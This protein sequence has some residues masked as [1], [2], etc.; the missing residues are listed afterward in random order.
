MTAS[1]HA[2]DLLPLDAIRAKL[3]RAERDGAPLGNIWRTLRRETQAA[4]DAHAWYTPFVAAVTGDEALRQDAK[5]IIARFLEYAELGPLGSGVQFHFWCFAFP[6]ARWA[7]WFDLLRRLGAYGEREAEETAAT[8]LRLQL[9]DY[10]SGLLT[11]PHPECVDNQ[12]ASLCLSSVVLGTLF[13]DGPGDGTLAMELREEALGRAEAMIGGMPASGYSGEGSTYQGVV[14][15]ITIPF[16]VEFLERAVGGDWFDRPCAPNGTSAHDI[17]RMTVR[18]WQPSGLLLPWDDYGYQFG[19]KA[20]IAF[21]ARRTGEGAYLRILEDAANWNDNPS[22]GWGFDDPVWALVHWPEARADA[23]RDWQPWAAEHLGGVLV[24]PDGTRYLMQMWDETIPKPTRPHV[25]PNALVLEADGIPLTADGAKSDECHA[26]DFDDTWVERR[27]QN[28]GITRF[29][30]G[31]STGA[32]HGVLLVDGW[33]TLRPAAGFAAQTLHDFD[34]DGQTLT[35][36]VTGLYASVYP[37]CRR[38]L[39]RSRLV[40]DRAWLVE[41][42]ARFDE[43]HEVTSRW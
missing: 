22:A 43:A 41:D 29:S 37:D 23:V 38:V 33:E 39:R 30:Y 16:F 40:A 15:A 18:L 6:F 36:D 24:N 35:G 21:L 7:I 4:P 12:A 19:C 10:H 5:R 27:G 11:K 20:P 8:F 1:I 26:F 17:L 25:N 34:A 28:F 13:A 3:D 31:K 32:G 2:E 42:L 9:R 14:V